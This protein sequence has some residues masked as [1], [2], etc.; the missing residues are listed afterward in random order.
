MYILSTPNTHIRVC[1]YIYE[2]EREREI[3]PT[4][5]TGQDMQQAD[6]KARSKAQIFELLV[7]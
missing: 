6:G 1:V 2:R 4:K 5:L 3:D 7:R